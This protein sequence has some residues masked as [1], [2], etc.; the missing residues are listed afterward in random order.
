MSYLYKGYQSGSLDQQEMEEWSRAV[1][2]LS[3]DNDFMEMVDSDW[4]RT[5]LLSPVWEKDEQESIYQ[6]IITQPQKQYAKQVKLDIRLGIAVAVTIAVLSAGLWFYNSR[7]TKIDPVQIA[8]DVNPGKQGATLTLGNGKKIRLDSAGNGELAKQAGLTITK[9][10]NGQLAYELRN[11]DQTADVNTMNTLSTSKGETIALRLPDGTSV[12][13]NAASSL[14][15]NAAL[16]KNGKRKVQLDGEGYF[17]VARDRAHPFIVESRGQ[18]VEVLGTHFNINSY[19][20]E[21]SINTTLLEGSVKVSRNSTVKILKP[22][23]AAA[24]DGTAIKVSQVDSEI[25]VA[26][27]NEQFL[28]EHEDIRTIMRKI[29]RWYDVEVIYEDELA[30]ETFSGG[31]SRF[32][33]LSK[34]LKSLEL[35]SRAH[36]KV[37]GRKV[38]VLK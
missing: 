15:Y 31:V 6:Y 34:V 32:D 2:D 4:Y 25:A 20:D 21:P 10:A 12:W 13:L 26:W 9:L 23:E 22:G 37:I 8:T 38:Y 17:E 33:Q 30:G 35:T 29:S 36:F 14:T 3:L 18:Q 7:E 16:L 24:V 19:A 1:S 28:F 27:K 5:D 11:A